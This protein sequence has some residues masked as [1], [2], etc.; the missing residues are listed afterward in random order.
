MR[1]RRNRLARAVGNLLDNAIKF[2]PP[3]GTV[4]VASAAGE[5][6]V[7]DQGPGIDEADLPRVFDRFYRS[8]RSRGLPGSGLGLAIVAQVA[9]EAGG[10]VVA[11]RSESL[12]GARL[13]LH[14]PL[15][16]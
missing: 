13:V 6:V 16:D 1:A 14:L 15:A 4:S 10:T 7:E 5:V 3:G 11:S 12:G 2:S 9:N 8:S